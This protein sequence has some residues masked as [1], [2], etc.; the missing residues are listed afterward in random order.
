MGI[1]TLCI[2]MSLGG[3]LMRFLVDKSHWQN[4][5]VVG[6]IT[7]GLFILSV[8]E[9]GELNATSVFVFFAGA[10]SCALGAHYS[11]WPKESATKKVEE[12][13]NPAN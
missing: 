1:A 12:T 11:P 7:G 6:A 4:A 8:G 3:M 5:F 2:S 9:R 13:P 10:V